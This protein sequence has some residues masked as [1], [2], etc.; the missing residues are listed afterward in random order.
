MI[1]FR[2]LLLRALARTKFVNAKYY[3]QKYEDVARAALDSNYH[4]FKYGI[5]EGRYPN[6][7]TERFADW[8]YATTTKFLIRF[9]LDESY[10]LRTYRDVREEGISPNVHYALSGRKEKR[11]INRF[12]ATMSGLIYFA[13]L[14]L[15]SLSKNS[16]ARESEVALYKYTIF[17]S[18]RKGIFE[19]IKSKAISRQL[20]ANDSGEKIFLSKLETIEFFDL[21]EAGYKLEDIEPA[22]SMDFQEPEIIDSNAE[23]PLRRAEV[24][25][26]WLATIDDA[27][28][29]GG[30]QVV[31][32]HRLVIYEPAADPHQGFV[33]GIWPYV[34]S[35]DEK[36]EVLFWFRYKKEISIP[37]AILLSGR[38]SPNYY[39]WLIEYLGKSYILSQQDRLR[40]TP[41][42]VDDK[43]FPQEFESL[44][45]MLPDWPIYRLDDSTLLKVKKLHVVSACTNLTDNLRGP[46]WKFSAIC[47]KTLG[48]MRSTVFQRFGIE[49]AGAGHRKVFLARRT[50]R[51]II[52]TPEVEEVLA[53]Y[54][55]EIVDTGQLS[56]EQQVR[57]FA[58]ARTIVG[59]MGAAFTNLIFCQPGTQVL[60]LSSPYTQLFCSQSNMAL[61]AGCSYQILVG[62]HALFQP[63]DE[64]TVSDPSLFLDSYAI[65]PKKLAAALAHIERQ[66]VEASAAK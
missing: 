46:M 32:K 6:H 11:Y 4:Y 57:L 28:V 65:D 29:L 17:E 38:C 33:A 54:G 34:V 25:R 39:H 64:H 52:N 45:A 12:F 48:H 23:R 5:K 51:N 62:E 7:T 24:P 42:I 30:F 47:F 44:Q 56:F 26:K 66:A 40:K 2:S 15:T 10:Y 8:F 50:G 3:K 9:C 13:K 31:A 36:S 35:L 22:Y 43:M 53:S 59:A 61:F 63:G 14:E 18:A 58:E 60:A 19:E 41:L 20:S 1:R 16:A 55:Y 21:P 49:E 37:S 27:A